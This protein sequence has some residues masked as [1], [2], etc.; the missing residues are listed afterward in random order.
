M[1]WIFLTKNKFWNE[2]K[3]E[4]SWSKIMPVLCDLLCAYALVGLKI[5]WEEEGDLVFL[6]WVSS[7]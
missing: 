3:I 4:Q 1:I 7:I 2:N 5:L 6:N